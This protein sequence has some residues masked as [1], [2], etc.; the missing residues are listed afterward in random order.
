MCA[1][2]GRG[3]HI[4][5]YKAIRLVDVVTAACLLNVAR[6]AMTDLFAQGLQSEL[7]ILAAL[8]NTTYT[9]SSIADVV[10]IK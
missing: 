4:P 3:L 5:E 8:L 1:Q 10:L 6:V 7:A 2:S 9:I